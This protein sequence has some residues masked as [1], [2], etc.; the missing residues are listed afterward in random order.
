MLLKKKKKI[1]LKYDFQTWMV[2]ELNFFD[3]I[4]WS[5]WIIYFDL[6]IGILLPRNLMHRRPSFYVYRMLTL[7]VLSVFET[8]YSMIWI[9]AF[10]V[11]LATQNEQVK[12]LGK[13]IHVFLSNIKQW[14]VWIVVTLFCP[15]LYLFN[16]TLLLSML[17]FLWWFQFDV[18]Q[19]RVI[20]DYRHLKQ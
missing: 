17:L 5:Y 9:L 11:M 4:N 10:Q 13:G 6:R 8:I 16:V 12:A 3:L 15:F 2:N 1:K 20:S 7:L 18:Y 19:L 14:I